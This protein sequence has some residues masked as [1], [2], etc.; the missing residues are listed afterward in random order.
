MTS[1]EGFL[2]QSNSSSQISTWTELDKA[3]DIF[4][5]KSNNGTFIAPQMKSFGPKKFQ[6][7]GTDQKVPFWQFFSHTLI[8][9]PSRFPHMI[10]KILF[11]LSFYEF[12]VML[13]DKLERPHFWSQ[14]PYNRYV[15]VVVLVLGSIQKFCLKIAEIENCQNWKLLGLKVVKNASCQNC[16]LPKL[17]V[18]K[19]ASCQNW[20]LPK[21]QVVKVEIDF[22]ISC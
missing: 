4:W 17:L 15:V 2:R 9:R 8:V 7:P 14:D 11:V 13:I 3:W 22:F 19:I 6:I 12:I 5:I 21:L 18:A 1:F 20:K 16:K 10:S